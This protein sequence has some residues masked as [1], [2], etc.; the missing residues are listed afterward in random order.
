MKCIRVVSGAVYERR[1]ILSSCERLRF[2]FQFKRTRLCRSICP[3]DRYLRFQTVPTHQISQ[4]CPRE[5]KLVR[6][7]VLMSKSV[8]RV[9]F[10]FFLEVESILLARTMTDFSSMT[11]SMSESISV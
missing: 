1:W 4:L 10:T 2:F 7:E 3:L 11:M 6:S 9:C 8:E 5:G